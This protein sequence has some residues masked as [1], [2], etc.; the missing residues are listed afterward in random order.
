MTYATKSKIK[1]FGQNTMSVL[2]IDFKPTA[3]KAHD[4]LNNRWMLLQ[5][6]KTS[7]PDKG[8]MEG[9]LEIT[10]PLIVGVGGRGGLL[11]ERFHYI[12]GLSEPSSIM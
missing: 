6:G 12:L 1:L 3:S 7:W 5:K 11:L 10:C 2:L 9:I 4:G 8:Y